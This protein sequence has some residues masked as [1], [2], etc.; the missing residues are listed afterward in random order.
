MANVCCPRNG[1]QVL[2]HKSG[3]CLLSHCAQAW[4]GPTVRP[5]SPDTGQIRWK[6]SRFRVNLAYGD[7]GW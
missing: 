3:S 7:V 5:A 1:K 2:L 4:E 6:R